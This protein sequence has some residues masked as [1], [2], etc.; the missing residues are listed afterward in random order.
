M[1]RFHKFMKEN[2]PGFEKLRLV[3]LGN[4]PGV[5]DSRRIFGGY[6]LK[7]IDVACG[8]KFVNSNR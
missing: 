6:M 3:G 8:S 2:V 7:T 4:V 1:K 5:R